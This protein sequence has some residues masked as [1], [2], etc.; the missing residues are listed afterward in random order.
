MGVAGRVRVGGFISLLGKRN[1]PQILEFIPSTQSN[2]YH[3]T[4]TATITSTANTMSTNEKRK[5][6]NKRR[7][8]QN[9]N[10]TLN[11][12]DAERRASASRRL[13]AIETPD[14]HTKRQNQDTAKV[15]PLIS[16]TILTYRQ[17]DRTLTNALW[18]DTVSQHPE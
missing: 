10:F 17:L 1:Q 11:Y 7:T 9:I 15:K 4:R 5:F 3:A 18:L 12:L 14:T 2:I 16:T 6:P 13:E 8:S